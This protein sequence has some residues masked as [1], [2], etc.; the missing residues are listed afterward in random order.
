MSVDLISRQ[1]VVRSGCCCGLSHFTC[2]N[3]YSGIT[4]FSSWP[5]FCYSIGMFSAF[6]L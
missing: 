2:A 4:G 5:S 3:S 1:L 6:S